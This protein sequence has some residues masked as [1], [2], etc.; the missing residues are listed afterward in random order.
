MDLHT[1]NSL[2]HHT[3]RDRILVMIRDLTIM[4]VVE[5]AGVATIVDVN[6]AEA[7]LEA[8]TVTLMI[9]VGL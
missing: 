5:E 2:H 4:T 6:E 3:L 1:H 7:E 8:G 9:N